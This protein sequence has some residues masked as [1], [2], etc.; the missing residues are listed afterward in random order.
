MFVMGWVNGISWYQTLLWCFHDRCI[1]EW[2]TG[3]LAFALGS[4]TAAS[5]DQIGMDM[6]LTTLQ[7]CT[8]VPFQAVFQ[9][10]D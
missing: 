8:H 4:A 3:I 1:S 9:A 5:V 10:S 6:F 7:D 2:G